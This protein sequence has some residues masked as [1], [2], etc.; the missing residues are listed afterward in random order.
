MILEWKPICTPILKKL[1]HEEI[2]SSKPAQLAK[3]EMEIA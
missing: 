1:F 3:L 2:S